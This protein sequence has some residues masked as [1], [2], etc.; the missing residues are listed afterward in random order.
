MKPKGMSTQIDD[1]CQKAI[2]DNDDD[3]GLI[4]A[5]KA[6]DADAC[7]AAI[8]AGADVGSDGSA[9]GPLHWAC[10]K[11]DARMCEILIDAGASL[12]VRYAEPTPL[13]VASDG[14]YTDVVELL[15]A[16]GSDVY[17]VSSSGK[18]AMVVAVERR[19][20]DIC[21]MLSRSKAEANASDS[22]SRTG[23]MHAARAGDVELCRVLLDAGASID[24]EDMLGWTALALAVL[25]DRLDVCKF[26]V[27]KGA[28]RVFSIA[29]EPELTAFQFAVRQGA[30]ASAAYLLGEF[31]ED[32][33]QRTAAGKTM[34]QLAGK[35]QLMKDLL[36]SAKTAGAV[37]S[38]LGA[39]RKMRSATSP[40][41][42][43]RSGVGPI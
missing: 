24:S 41:E 23:L 2:M 36:H 21:K 40:R 31:G 18:A 6:G 15:L 28:S 12:G 42:A 17:A 16:A 35:N 7:L 27:E 4:E 29:R 14:G 30:V 13:M 39:S 22:S 43:R 11:G 20:V 34:V 33:A 19:H 9:W 26:L 25:E 37:D 10:A 8:E 38:S 3:H 32:P 1:R 5:I